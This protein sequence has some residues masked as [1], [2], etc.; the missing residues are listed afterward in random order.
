[1]GL[2]IHIGIRIQSGGIGKINDSIKLVI[3]SNLVDFF[4]LAK[5][6]TLSNA[7][8]KDN[9]FIYNS[10]FESSNTK[11]SNFSTT[12]KLLELPG[13]TK[14]SFVITVTNS[15]SLL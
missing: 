11:S 4:D 14:P 6:I 2:D 15:N 5:I 7:V 1:M 9:L 10:N 8:K 3:E 12:T 13:L